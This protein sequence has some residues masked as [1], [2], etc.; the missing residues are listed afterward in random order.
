M[1]TIELILLV[2]V[3]LLFIVVLFFLIRLN[4]IEKAIT[5][6]NYR[7][8]PVRLNFLWGVKVL[9]C[10]QERYEEVEEVNGLIEDEYGKEA[11]NS[12]PDDLIGML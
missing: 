4:R 10:K 11:L 7:I 5:Y 12:S 9:L 6:T 2:L 3:A 8:D 1:T